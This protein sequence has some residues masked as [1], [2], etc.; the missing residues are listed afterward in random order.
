[1]KHAI[2]AAL[3][4]LGLLGPARRLR[5]LW[6][7]AGFAR[8]NREYLR[9]GLPGGLPVPPARLRILVAASPDLAWFIESGRRGADSIRAALARHGVPADS[10][11]ILDFGCGCGRVLRHL[12]GI[13]VPVDGSDLDPRLVAWCR[14]HLSTGQ[15]V[16]NGI[17]PPIPLP[18]G[19]YS[20]VYALSVFTHLPEELQRAWMDEMRRVL[21]PGGHLL[22][23]T[24]GARYANELDADERSRFDAGR[25]VVRRDDS[26]GSNVCG[27]YHPEAYIRRELARGFTVVE[28]A[29]EG[30]A[31]NPWQ[32]LWLLRRDES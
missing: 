28:F 12:A 24:H 1:M 3:S 15:F 2:R 13:G 18:D 7:T 22:F 5:E 6:W 17:A 8:A 27:A 30:A 19:R 9:R 25:L 23:T 21:R 4:R 20:L 26:P 31:G 11:P 16:V 29:P 32:D 10:G 14:R